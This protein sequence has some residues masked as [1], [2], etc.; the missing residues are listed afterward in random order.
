[1]AQ[2]GQEVGRARRLAVMAVAQHEQ[3]R[4][5]HSLDTA[6]RAEL[7]DPAALLP[8]VQQ[9]FL[10]GQMAGI[11]LSSEDPDERKRAGKHLE[12]AQ[13]RWQEVVDAAAHQGDLAGLLQSVRARVH[14]ERPAQ[15][16]EPPDA[17]PE[18]GAGN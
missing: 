3:G 1:M 10:H 8:I 12:R 15:P 4:I 5:E 18:D 17:E 13:K 11:F 7:A 6:R 14:L 9:A 16:A 2:A